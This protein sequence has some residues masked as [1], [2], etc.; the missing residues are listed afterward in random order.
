MRS[1]EIRDYTHTLLYDGQCVICRFLVN[2]FFGANKPSLMRL[3][4]YQEAQ[5]TKIYP[6]QELAK[7]K[8]QILIVDD[9]QPKFFGGV[10]AISLSLKLSG[11]LKPIQSILNFKPIKPLLNFGYKMVAWHRYSWFTIPPYLRCAECEIN[12]PKFWNILFFAI[13]SSLS[14]GAY[15]LF[16][17]LWFNFF[18]GAAPVLFSTL[19]IK[20]SVYALASVS[21]ASV[22]HLLLS[23]IIYYSKQKS[24]G[25]HRIEGAK[26]YLLWS[27]VCSLLLLLF[28][29][30]AIFLGSW[31]ASFTNALRMNL[32]FILLTCTFLSASLFATIALFKRLQSLKRQTIQN[33]F[34]VVVDLLVK[35]FLP[36][37]LLRY[38]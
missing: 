32:V 11:Q 33:L 20:N 9:S 23:A 5:A 36:F 31:I 24:I 30:S 35:C 38:L 27:F 19:T 4:P 37:V 10:E 28:A 1:E 18:R 14:F 21:A 22:I 6:E 29:P 15:L 2:N 25:I 34:F 17:N 3:M 26:Q 13:F 7:C 12:I 16:C 8:Q